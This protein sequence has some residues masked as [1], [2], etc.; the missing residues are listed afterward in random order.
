[1]A[2]AQPID[3]EEISA[4]KMFDDV[5]RELIA[6]NVVFTPEQTQTRFDAALSPPQV[7]AKLRELLSNPWSETWRKTPSQPNRQPPQREHK[8]GHSTVY[9]ILRDHA[10]NT[11]TSK[12]AKQ[13]C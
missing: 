4:E 11:P 8:R 1:M 9:R 6:W 13:R 12:P 7:K 3:A 10:A 2:E 5:Q